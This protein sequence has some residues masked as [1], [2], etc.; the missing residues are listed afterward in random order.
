MNYAAY[1]SLLLN[2]A[3]CQSYEMESGDAPCAIGTELLREPL[4]ALTEDLAFL[5][6]R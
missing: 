4:Q 3:A 2:C 1:N 5:A 6:K